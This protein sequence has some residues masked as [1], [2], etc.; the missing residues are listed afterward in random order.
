LSVRP[1]HVAGVD[2]TYTNC[3]GCQQGVWQF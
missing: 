2:G 1:K 3:S